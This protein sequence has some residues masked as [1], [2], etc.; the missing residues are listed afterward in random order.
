M[1]RAA[2]A[3]SG[4]VARSCRA[5]LEGPSLHRSDCCLS[6][7]FSVLPLG[8]GRR[9]TRSGNRRRRQTQRVAPDREDAAGAAS[10]CSQ[11][12]A[13]GIGRGSIVVCLCRS[14]S[15]RSASVS[16]RRLVR[17]PSMPRLP[18]LRPRR[19]SL[20]VRALGVHFPGAVPVV[21]AR[22]RLHFASGP[23]SRRA[24]VS[25]RLLVPPF[26]DSTSWALRLQ[27]PHLC[28]PVAPLYRGVLAP[29]AATRSA[30]VPVRWAAAWFRTFL[31][32]QFSPPSG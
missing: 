17:V 19:R 22:L 16:L 26:S 28:F 24:A 18:G 8:F 21:R 12:R 30:R 1:R 27:A 13:S 10:L 25:A 11:G 6:L 4:A 20:P 23:S 29:C 7:P 5:G 3:A 32:G 9:R 31:R 14:R 15:C 2:F